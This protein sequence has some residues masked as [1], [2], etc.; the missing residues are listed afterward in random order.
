M[1]FDEYLYDVREVQ[2][3]IVTTNEYIDPKNYDNPIQV[4]TNDHY[5]A[6][7]DTNSITYFDLLIQK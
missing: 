1:T 5:Y 6:I 2:I 3:M 7:L 4:V